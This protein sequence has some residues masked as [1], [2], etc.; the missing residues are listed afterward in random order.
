MHGK[1]VFTWADGRI[2]NG[3]YFNDKKHGYGEF[4]WPDGKKYCG[5]WQ[6]GK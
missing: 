5:L 1:G 6:D 2:Y 3:D 4:T